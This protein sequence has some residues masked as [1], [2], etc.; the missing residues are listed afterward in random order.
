MPSCVGHRKS[1]EPLCPQ[2]QEIVPKKNEELWDSLSQQF[3]T[4]DFEGRAIDWLAGAVRIP[5]E[6]YDRMD[7]VGVDPRWE[8]F[9][10]FHDFL[11]QSF[12]LIHSTLKV[13]KV[14]TYGLVYHWQGSDADLKPIL[15]AA[16]QDV[17]PVHPNTVKEWK[18]PPYS[19][20]FDGK[21]IWGR[22][23]IDDKSGL[24]GIMASI[25]SLLEKSFHPTRSVV[26]AFGFDEEA[27][28]IYGASL[29]GEHMMKVYGENA[30]AFIIDEGAG[31]GEQFGTVVASLG[32]AE[33]G[34]VDVR[35]D[36]ASPGGHSSIPPPH[37]SIGMLA[38]L[39]VE[40]ESNPYEVHLARGTPVY[41]S[42]ECLAA[43][44]PSLPSHV[45]KN[46]KKAATSNKALK[47]VE[48]YFFQVPAFKSLTGS[49]QAIDLIGGGVKTNALPEQAWAVVNHRIAT[50]SSVGALIERD[51]ALLQSLASQFNLSYTA[52]GV[53]Q[54]DE[55]VPAFGT[56]TLSEAFMKGLEPAPI[57]PV[58]EHPYELLSGTIKAT[59][60]K[61]RGRAL[62]GEDE[63]VIAPGIMSGNT[64][65]RHYWGLTEHIFRYN[66]RNQGNGS[67][68]AG[69]V[70]T[71]N[72]VIAVDTF[73]E[74]ILFFTGLIL[75]ADESTGL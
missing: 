46:F 20:H 41:A 71:T 50:E 31:F 42:L 33:K 24:I 44:A 51:T 73:L 8:V 56:L 66:H 38:A 63:I 75:N 25:E 65:T 10:P 21:S 7:A 6:S 4:N 29:L 49:T 23:S 48:D 68:L 2:V 58:D 59:Y 1:S 72:E 43:H 30:F 16:H 37:T 18:Y 12:P 11:L 13:T 19:G 34:Y 39:L 15:L 45:K 32:I 14:N 60:N 74:M 35:V 22:G 40:F 62:R 69:G 67:A 5:T 57:T 61:H 3:T 9:G 36:V 53:G 64:D 47:K 54:S 26:M 52:F 70:H 27:S 55:G 28:G 17:V